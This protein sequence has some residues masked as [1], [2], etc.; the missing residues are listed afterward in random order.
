MQLKSS[1]WLVRRNGR[2]D[3][4]QRPTYINSLKNTV[5]LIRESVSTVGSEKTSSA[6]NSPLTLNSIASHS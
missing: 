2:V 1:D 4:K 3:E 5:R 6:T